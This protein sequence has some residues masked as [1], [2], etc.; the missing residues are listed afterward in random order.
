MVAGAITVEV[1]FNWPGLGTLT[2]EALAVRAATEA[3]LESEDTFAR[4]LA[5]F[6]LEKALYELG[7]EMN[8]RPDWLWVPVQGILSISERSL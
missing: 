8:N 5:A 7:Y 6:E 3:Y 1:V 2:V 4:V